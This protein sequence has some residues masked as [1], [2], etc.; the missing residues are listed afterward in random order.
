MN[1]TNFSIKSVNSI[2]NYDIPIEDNTLILVGENGTGKSTILSMLNCIVS[3]K[4]TKII[5]YNFKSVEIE[6]DGEK[7]SFTKKEVKD[8]IM[9][10]RNPRNST[11]RIE[12]YLKKILTKEGIDIDKAINDPN[13][14][15][16]LLDHIQY[17]TPLKLTSKGLDRALYSIL[18][19]QDLF[20]DN[21]V[22][23]LNISN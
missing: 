5:D 18:D 17:Q 22:G 14:R 1:I 23:I 13:T 21:N 2:Y 20:I 11:A 8:Y 19:Q 3:R 16:V 15:E 6:I 7:Y 4:W 10:E 12:M 9:I